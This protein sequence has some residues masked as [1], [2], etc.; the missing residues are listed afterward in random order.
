MDTAIAVLA[1]ANFIQYEKGRDHAMPMIL[2]TGVL[3]FFI[4]YFIQAACIKANHVMIRIL[5]IICFLLFAAAF[6][7]LTNLIFQGG[8][9]LTST[10]DLFSYYLMPVIFTLLGIIIFATSAFGILS[11]WFIHGITIWWKN[12]N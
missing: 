9:S 5:P 11:A 7:I 10:K 12:K 2:L 1:Q 4:S 6:Y 8:T 3:F